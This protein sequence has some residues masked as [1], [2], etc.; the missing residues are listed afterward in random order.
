LAEHAVIAHLRLSAGGFG[1]PT[2]RQRLM[3]LEHRLEQSIKKA[4]VGE[5][6]GNEFGD[7]ECVW[8][9]YGPDAEALYSAVQPIVREAAT[10]A[11][12]FVV[13]RRGAPGD[14]DAKEERI[15]L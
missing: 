13:K 2:E 12:S 5:F 9:M 15:E 14:P 3:E 6:D 7:G 11:G 1:T 10:Q 4:G 8:Y